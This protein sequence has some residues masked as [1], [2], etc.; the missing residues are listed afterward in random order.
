MKNNITTYLKPYAIE[1]I[2]ASDNRANFYLRATGNAVPT[3]M[4]RL[5]KVM[6][7]ACHVCKCW[8]KTGVLSDTPMLD[9]YVVMEKRVSGYRSNTLPLFSTIK[10]GDTL[11]IVPKTHIE[12]IEL[13]N[14]NPMAYEIK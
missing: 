3:D 9:G 7:L 13:F 4:V 2:I 14:T 6:T 8:L 10:L 11:Y 5:N 1:K 12:C